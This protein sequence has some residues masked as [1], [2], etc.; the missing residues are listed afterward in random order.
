M[1]GNTPLI[2]ATATNQLETVKYLIENGA[3][4]NAKNDV[5]V[6]SCEGCL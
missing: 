2:L 5:S 4:I 6:S 1:N 3:T